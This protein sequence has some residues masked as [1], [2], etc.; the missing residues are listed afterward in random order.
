MDLDPTYVPA[1]ERLLADTNA[2]LSKYIE[3]GRSIREANRLIDANAVGYSVENLYKEL[4]APLRGRVEIVYDDNNHPFLRFVESLLYGPYGHYDERHQSLLLSTVVSDNRGFILSTPRLEEEQHVGLN[5]PF[6]STLIDRLF[7]ARTEPVIAEDLAADFSLQGAKRSRFLEL[8]TETPPVGDATEM[9]GTGVRIRYF[10]HA[11]VLIQTADVSILIDPTMSYRY[12]GVGMGDRFTIDDLPQH[13]DYVLLTHDHQDHTCLEFLLQLR[14]RIGT[15]VVP[16]ASG[17]T[18]LNPSTKRLLGAVGFA[19]VV[20][21]DELES[22]GSGS[23][24]ITGLPFFGEHGDLGI[25][26][27]LGYHVRVAGR[28]ALFLADSKNLDTELYRLLHAQLGDVD[29]AFIGMECDGAPVSWLYGP[30]LRQSLPRKMDQTRR[31]SGSNSKEAFDITT[32]FRCKKAYVYAMGQEPWLGFLTT[33]LYTE[34]SSP[35]IESNRFVAACRDVGIESER[36]YGKKEIF[37]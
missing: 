29:I 35:I 12:E 36:L 11:C 27:K 28:S 4:P 6:S 13:I 26:A 14:Q 1:I 18:L 31:L 34:E 20:E 19:K 2:G 37:L 22:I 21:L 3:L 15:I 25:S 33:V 10:G 7:G 9:Q 5:V 17:G 8:F 23:H 30:L 16:R 24:C 32:V